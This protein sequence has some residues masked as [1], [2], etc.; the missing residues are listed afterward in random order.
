MA[1][2]RDGQGWHS[3]SELGLATTDV[4]GPAKQREIGKRVGLVMAFRKINAPDT[5]GALGHN[6][7]D[8]NVKISVISFE[9]PHPSSQPATWL[10]KFCPPRRSNGHSGEIA[11]SDRLE[12][13]CRAS[14]Y[15]PSGV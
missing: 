1:P 8:L 10:Q 11:R 9:N 13:L 2:R 7:Q 3:A 5:L 14:R 6:S 15:I 4:P 12:L